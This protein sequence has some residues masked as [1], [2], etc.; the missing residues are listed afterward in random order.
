L[1]SAAIA[2]SFGMYCTRATCGVSSVMIERTFAISA[3]VTR[4]CR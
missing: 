2:F 4:G 1:R 3:S